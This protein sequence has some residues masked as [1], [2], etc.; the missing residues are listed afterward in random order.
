MATAASLASSVMISTWRLRE[1]VELRAL[2]VEHAD[3]AVLQQQ[4][5]DQLRPHVVHDLDVARV[6][7]DV[8]HEH[9]FLVQRRVADQALPDLDVRRAGACRRSRPPPSSRAPASPRSPAGCRTCGSR[10]SRRVR[11][12]IRVSS[13][14]RSRI[15]PNSRA[16][17]ASVS[18]VVG[19]LALALEQ[20]GVF[21]GHRH[22]RP[23]LPQHRLVDFGELPGGVAEQ[24][25][26]ADRRAPC[27]AAARPAPRSS[28]APLRRSADR[29]ARR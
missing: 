16:I 9:R 3:A 12:A 7:V 8:R 25:E 23:E 15:A 17:S 19:V 21:D 27:D 2:E 18:S 5:D 4:R 1:R 13:S 11:L 26:R 20:P 6:G 14:S 29:R 22:V 28:R 24:V 10:S